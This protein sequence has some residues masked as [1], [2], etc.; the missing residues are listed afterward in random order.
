MKHWS[1]RF[2]LF[3][4]ILGLVMPLNIKSASASTLTQRVSG[5][6]ISTSRPFQTSSGVLVSQAA[7]R[8]SGAYEYIG[9]PYFKVCT[10]RRYKS[11]WTGRWQEQTVACSYP[12]PLT[13]NGAVQTVTSSCRYGEGNY[14]TEARWREGTA[15]DFLTI[16][17][18]PPTSLAEVSF[19]L[20]LSWATGGIT[21]YNTQYRHPSWFVCT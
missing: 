5:C 13:S 11:G 12:K 19:D 20:L 9:L 14:Y 3:F 8:C 2:I 15:S 1:T 18:L 6:A 21:K 4:V 10:V 16:V 17:G 7:F